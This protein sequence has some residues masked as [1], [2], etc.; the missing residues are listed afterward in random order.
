MAVAH[1]V[2]NAQ[3]IGRTFAQAI[4]GEP[5]RGLWVRT[6]RGYVELWLLTAPVDLATERRLHTAT[7]SLIEKFPKANFR[8]RVVNPRHAEPSEDPRTIIPTD[9]E[10]VDL[11]AKQ[12]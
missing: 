4:Q 10:L 9:A 11:A 12:D 5:I 3:E 6:V 8:L 7:R 2:P 1:Y